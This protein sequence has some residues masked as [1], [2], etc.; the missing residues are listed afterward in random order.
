MVPTSEELDRIGPK[1]TCGKRRSRAVARSVVI[2]KWT[3]PE[4]PYVYWTRSALYP[5]FVYHM[6]ASKASSRLVL[7]TSVTK[8]RNNRHLCIKG[9]GWGKAK[10]KEGFRWGFLTSRQ[11]EW[12]I[13]FSHHAVTKDR[14]KRHLWSQGEIIDVVKHPCWEKSSTKA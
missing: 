8:L 10:S 6:W 5:N 1:P 11:S 3:F 7:D 9:L 14:N 2:P 4:G 12:Y 13:G